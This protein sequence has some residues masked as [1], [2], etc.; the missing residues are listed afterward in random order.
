MSWSEGPTLNGESFEFESIKSTSRGI[1]TVALPAAA[2]RC[3]PRPVEESFTI[4]SV[5]HAVA[6]DAGTDRERI[7][8]N[9]ICNNNNYKYYKSKD[10]GNNT[11]SGGDEK[12][13]AE[14]MFRCEFKKCSATFGSEAARA[15]HERTTH[16]K[17]VQCPRPGCNARIRKSGL[18]SHLKLIHDSEN[19]N[20][21][22]CGK[23]VRPSYLYIH[24]GIC[25]SKS[26]APGA[27]DA[28]RDRNLKCSY[29]G[30]SRTFSTAF[31]RR[32]HEGRYHSTWNRDRPTPNPSTSPNPASLP[33]PASSIS[34]SSSR[35]STSATNGEKSRLLL[36]MIQD[37][38]VGSVQELVGD[39]D[40][41][42]DTPAQEIDIAESSGS[43]Y[44]VEKVID[45]E[46]Y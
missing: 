35:D 42:G 21:E 17:K 46:N 22:I 7:R 5:R 10:L 29:E 4:E 28:D 13:R 34:E 37:E 23:S 26:P 8:C 2:L 24:R 39:L 11:P 15:N 6:R 32:V 9:K 41:G 31:Y 16:R 14:I 25:G 12:I 45:F 1:E 20:C 36:E 3:E 40:E 18:S 27:S 30:C 44:V 38:S 43:L 33:A 19:V